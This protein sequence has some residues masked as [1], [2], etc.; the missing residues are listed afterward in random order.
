MKS[1]LYSTIIITNK[2]NQKTKIFTVNH[3]H[4]ENMRLYRRLA[5][6]FVLLF[7]ALILSTIIYVNFSFDQKHS[8]ENK[9]ADLNNRLDEKKIYKRLREIDK[10][11]KSLKDIEKYLKD[12]NIS[13]G[14]QT[15]NNTKNTGGEVVPIENFSF[16]IVSSKQEWLSELCTKMHTIPIG[17]PHKGIITSEYGVRINPFHSEDGSECHAGID[18]DGHVGDPIKV[19]AD[20]I[21]SFADQKTGYGKCIVIKHAFGYET[22]YGHLS[23]ISVHNG[24][25][26]KSGQKI[27]E[28]GSTGRSTGPHIHYEVM[29]YDKKQNPRKF[30]NI[31]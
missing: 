8:L 21:V 19:T 27:G 16:D 3:K 15:Q 25:I 29:Q 13:I 1:K 6:G 30:L 24:Q 11:E 2:H 20:G 26:V 28:L 10:M 9:I 18:I 5:F 14:N 12:R 31:K 23:K 22:L 17:L 4:I 7:V